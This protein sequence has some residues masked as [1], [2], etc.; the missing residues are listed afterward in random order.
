MTNTIYFVEKQLKGSSHAEVQNH[1]LTQ[2]D[3]AK[4][5]STR[6]KNRCDHVVLLE[7]LNS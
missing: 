1:N 7:L 4:C 6:G 5:I 3:A 2:S